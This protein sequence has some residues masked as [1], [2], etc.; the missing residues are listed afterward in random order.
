LWPTDWRGAEE[1]LE[2]EPDRIRHVYDV[3]AVRVEPVG[4]VD[5]WPVSG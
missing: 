4:L 5:L 2:T 1:E 3:K